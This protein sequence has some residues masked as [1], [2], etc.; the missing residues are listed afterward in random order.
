M[1]RD[2][3]AVRDSQ[4]LRS[5]GR[6]W[7]GP[8]REQ[9]PQLLDHPAHQEE[10]PNYGSIAGDHHDPLRQRQRPRSAPQATFPDPL[11]HNLQ[12]ALKTGHLQPANVSSCIRST[13]MMR[14][15]Q[16]HTKRCSW[17]P[18]ACASVPPACML[19]QINRRRLNPPYRVGGCGQF[20]SI[21]TT[22][23]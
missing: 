13:P 2:Q 21:V 10:A 23:F 1:D 17:W 5:I 22:V 8:E 7:G 6:V 16:P 14:S 11:L 3:C 12:R 19:N 4:L 15:S 9:R 20:W 18:P